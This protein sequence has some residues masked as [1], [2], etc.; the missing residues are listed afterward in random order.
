MQMQNVLFALIITLYLAIAIVL[1]RKYLRSRDVGFAWLCAAVVGWP[2]LSPLLELGQRALMD[3]LRRGES[4]FFPFSLV[5]RG[6]LTAGD[7]IMF[8]GISRQFAGL[9]LLFIAVVY[10]GR[11]K[12][13]AEMPGRLETSQVHP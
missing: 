2:L 8:L 5:E 1:V 13:T 3:R 9:L 4:V 6:Q 7:L 10:L 11:T 12:S